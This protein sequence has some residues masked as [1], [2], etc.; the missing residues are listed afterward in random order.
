MDALT[1]LDLAFVTA[2]ALLGAA[3]IRESRQ[4]AKLA[5]E[6]VSGRVHP[7][8]GTGVHMEVAVVVAGWVYSKVPWT[9]GDPLFLPLPGLR[10]LGASPWTVARTGGCCS[11]KS[12]LL[13][14]LLRALR[15]EAFQVSLYHRDGRAR[16]ALVAVRSP[17]HKVLVDP[18]FGLR[19]AG[20]DGRP[21][22][23]KELRGGASHHYVALPQSEEASYPEG[24]YF[25]FDFT[26]TRTAGWT[27]DR[28][29][30]AAYS[31]LHRLT[32]GRIDTLPQ[33]AWMEWPH[34]IL[35]ALLA[36][37]WLSVQLAVALIR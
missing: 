2:I 37:S 14:C 20:E 6:I 30:R 32:R 13:I 25:D 31:V 1:L 21:L 35:G 12:R 24:D 18:L 22:G 11:G 7:R 33:P 8:L 36:L 26:E 23:L 16:H 29:R 9:F 17:Y 34:L 4:I 10:W 5:R 19:F 3:Y 15:Q 28:V 27:G